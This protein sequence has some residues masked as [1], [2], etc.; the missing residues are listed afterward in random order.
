[1]SALCTFAFDEQP[2]RVI[3]REDDPWFVASDVCRALAIANNR[4]ADRRGP[5]AGDVLV[6]D[7]HRSRERRPVM[8]AH[9][10]MLAV[11]MSPCGLVARY[12]WKLNAGG[13]R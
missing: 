1:M 6:H 8:M 9:L 4:D 13:V 10:L 11:A 5:G 3:M 7:L 2:V 12:C